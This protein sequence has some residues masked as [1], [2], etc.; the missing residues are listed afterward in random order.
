MPNWF[1]PIGTFLVLA[2]ALLQ[3]AASIWEDRTGR[4][5]CPGEH[6]LMMNRYPEIPEVG[7]DTVRACF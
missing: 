6:A 1:Y 7:V 3:A 4:I 2:Y 5:F